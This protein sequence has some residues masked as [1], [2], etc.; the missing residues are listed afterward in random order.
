MVAIKQ[1]QKARLKTF[2]MHNATLICHS[3]IKRPGINKKDWKVALSG[4]SKPP[5]TLNGLC[6][7]MKDGLLSL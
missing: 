4:V 2:H 1:Q 3:K 5:S 6:V 7:D